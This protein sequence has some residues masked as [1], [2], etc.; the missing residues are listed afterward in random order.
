MQTLVKAALSGQRRAIARLISVV[1][2]GGQEAR[3]I[4]ARLYPHTGRAYVVGI[5]GPPGSGKSTLVNQIAVE[6]RQRGMTVG[7][8][9]V[10][11]SSPL[12]GGALLGDRIRMRSLGG[13]PG[14]FVRSMAS[15]GSLGGLARSTTDVVR[16]LDACSFQRILLETVGAGQAEVDIARTA[17]TTAVVQVPG[18]GDD[19]QMLKAGI[20]E[21]ADLFI[22]N[23][24]DMEGA[25][26]VVAI[27][28][29]MLNLQQPEDMANAWRPPVVKTVA[30]T[31]E[32]VSLAVDEIERHM[33]YLHRNNLGQ[34]ERERAVSELEAILRDD[35]LQAALARFGN[36][37][38]SLVDRLINREIDP[39]SAALEIMRDVIRDES[40]T[41]GS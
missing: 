5:T 34:R 12:S 19:I 3:E 11:P 26:K 41:T 24:A 31:G 29:A 14:V 27:L 37:Y 36:R 38:P 8:V 39:Y 17:H 22:V 21:V 2:N 28:E 40:K 13:D 7:I 23:K 10:D 35:L 30:I 15:R 25:D 32:G 33:A 9:A 16:V 18:M 6:Y 1:E 4:I 20:L